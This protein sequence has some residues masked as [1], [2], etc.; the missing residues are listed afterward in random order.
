MREPIFDCKVIASL[1]RLLEAPVPI[2][3]WGWTSR[4]A[5]AVISTLELHMHIGWSRLT[6]KLSKCYLSIINNIHGAVNFRFCCWFEI[7]NWITSSA[8]RFLR[9]QD[10]HIH[11]ERTWS[12]LSCSEAL[13]IWWT[14]EWTFLE[15][16]FVDSQ[17]IK[18]SCNCQT[19]FF[20]PFYSIPNCHM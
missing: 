4:C 13:Q 14:S 8:S 7:R 1:Q 3:A 6:N 5:C 19:L 2:E 10:S 18:Q 11:L 16:D 20:I 17:F 15:R 9:F 12:C